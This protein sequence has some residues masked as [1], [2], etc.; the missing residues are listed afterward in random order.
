MNSIN[1]DIKYK[2]YVNTEHT[3]ITNKK[4]LNFCYI[5]CS[6]IAFKIKDQETVVTLNNSNQK[7]LL[8]RFVTNYFI[9]YGIENVMLINLLFFN[10][11]VS[12]A[13]NKKQLINS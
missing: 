1:I 3:K 9:F 11:L 5:H 4:K 6:F 10:V 8:K 2:K 7:F 13:F 12:Y